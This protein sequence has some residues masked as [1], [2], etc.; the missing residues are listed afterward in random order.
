MRLLVSAVDAAADRF[1]ARVIDAL[2]ADGAP[3][4][5]SGVGREALAR[6][7]VTLL[8]RGN[9]LS[10]VGL[11]EALPRAGAAA[12]TVL[13][14]S[15]RLLARQADA[16]LVVD[17]PELHLPLLRVARLAG[18]PAV[19]YLP[20][21]AWAWRAGR[22]R[23]IAWSGAR[24]ATVLPFESAWWRA[25][26]VFAEFVGHPI[27]DEPLPAR[28]PESGVCA[29]FPGSRPEEVRRHLAPMLGAARRLG[30]RP[31]VGLAPGVAPPAG[32]ETAS[33]AEAI[34]RAEVA[35]AKSGTICL[36]AALAGL[37]TVI[38]YRLARVTFALARRLVRVPHVGLPNLVLGRAAYPE[39]LQNDV[40]ADGIARALSAIAGRDFAG[41][42]AELRE[43]L[44]PSVSSDGVRR[45]GAARRVAALVRAAA[46]N[47]VD[48]FP[49]AASELRR[50]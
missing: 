41:E 27:L 43:R 34:A 25:R 31:I 42:A 1:A 14:L 20:P 26:G 30:M 33:G 38:V 5:A 46:A 4:E 49:T 21:Q 48:S 24:L 18:V 23:A 19:Y 47:S 35:I 15:A 6:A 37:P 40:S 7:G 13:R 44:G 17:A 29:I 2:R 45:P 9:D 22:A 10:A 28:R 12:R 8:R 36:E 50:T 3:L 16:L 39:L 32:V 11:V